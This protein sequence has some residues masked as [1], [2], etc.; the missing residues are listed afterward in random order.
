MLVA[1]C[2]NGMTNTVPSNLH[3]HLEMLSYSQMGFASKPPLM[4]NHHRYHVFRIAVACMSQVGV[5]S[6]WT[7]KNLSLDH[8]SM[9]DSPV[10]K[11]GGF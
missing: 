7:D 1:S 3:K 6:R 2:N 5:V 9:L 10:I 4:G 11:L 8:L